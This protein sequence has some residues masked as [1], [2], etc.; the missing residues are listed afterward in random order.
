MRGEEQRERTILVRGHFQDYLKNIKLKKKM[1]GVNV[2]LYTPDGFKPDD[3]DAQTVMTL[4]SNMMNPSKKDKKGKEDIDR[5]IGTALDKIL[6]A[7]NV[8]SQS[9]F[10]GTKSVVD[11]QIIE[12]NLT[13]LENTELDSYIKRATDITRLKN[14]D[15]FGRIF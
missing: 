15:L 5:L 7:D 13:K 3:K 4:C 14:G 11:K 9:D 2:R 1:G 10:N 8:R 12:T 6:I